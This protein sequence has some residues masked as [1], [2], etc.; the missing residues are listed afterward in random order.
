MALTSI[1]LI[2][3]GKTITS[4]MLDMPTRASICLLV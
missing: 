1:C 4:L 3:P 2:W